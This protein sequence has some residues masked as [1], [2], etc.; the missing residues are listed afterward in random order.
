[1]VKIRFK[2][3]PG[4]VQLFGIGKYRSELLE[5]FKSKCNRVKLHVPTDSYKY[6]LVVNCDYLVVF[7]YDSEKVVVNAQTTVASIF[8]FSRII[9][10][11][12]GVCLHQKERVLDIAYGFKNNFIYDDGE[13]SS[14]IKSNPNGLET[15][16]YPMFNYLSSIIDYALENEVIKKRLLELT[17]TCSVLEAVHNIASNPFDNVQEIYN[18]IK[19][20]E[21]K[22]EPALNMLTI[23]LWKETSV[24]TQW[25]LTIKVN[26]SGSK[27]F[28]IGGP[29][30]LVFDEDDKVWL[31][32]NVRQGTPNSSTFC[33]VLE[34]NGQPTSF[35][36]LF[37]GGLLGGGFGIAINNKKDEIAFGN[38]GWGS[39]DYNPQDGS[40]S[41]IRSDG[42]L[43]SPSNGFTNGFKRAQ[44]LCY[45]RCGNLWI[46]AWGD[47]SPLGG[48][49]PPIF[50]LP[51]SKSAVVVYIGGD[52]N[53]IATYEF[54][55]EYFHTFDVVADDCG[56]VYA[57][58]AG[59]NSQNVNSSIFHFKLLCGKIV[60]INSWTSDRAEGFRQVNISPKGTVVVAAVLTH[61]VLKFDKNL[62]MLGDFTN[63]MDGPWGV[64]FDE[65]GT[66]YVSNFREDTFVVHPSTYDMEGIF[67]VTIVYD[68]DDSTAQIAIL[69][70]GGDEILLNN[71]FPLYG[72]AGKPSYEPLQRMT[73]SQVDGAGNLWAMNNWKPALMAD[74][75]GNP[76]G[77]GAVV[78]IGLAEIN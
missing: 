7:R 46:A 53:N 36:P 34:S 78:F 55:N 69:P 48:G 17:N 19:D 38:F 58:N 52:P 47:Q 40:I 61:R 16:S 2:V 27:N 49:D 22:Y 75:G 74:L 76:S 32:N 6:F 33:T 14:V 21:P 50:D 68:E 39:S 56:N 51:S 66:M 10:F 28:L 54:D 30:Y 26:N 70:T 24:P 35:S 41:V 23:P 73:G 29:G 4:H 72:S 15:N 20:L 62:N 60:K 44:G 5:D 3:E 31:T 43:L 25:T 59:D 63:K 12:E 45:D 1:M 9:H 13:V 42:K 11:D 18:L 37:G 65:A 64:G 77:D 71:G 8:C 57:S 67:G